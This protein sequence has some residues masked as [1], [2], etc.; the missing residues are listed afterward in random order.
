MS[1]G[2]IGSSGLASIVPDVTTVQVP[3]KKQESMTRETYHGDVISIG[4][5]EPANDPTKLNYPPLFPL[6]D[7]QGIFK[8]D[9]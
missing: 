5:S 2:K 1:I 7:T 9:E 6:G 3:V 4:R 8:M